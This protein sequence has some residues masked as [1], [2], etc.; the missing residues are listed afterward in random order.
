MKA[1]GIVYKVIP[2]KETSS[3]VYLY[4]KFGHISVKSIGSKNKKNQSFLFDN[5]GNIVSFLITDNEFPTLIEYNLIKDQYDLTKDISMLKAFGIIIKIISYISNDLSH[6]RIYS[7]ILKTL[8][9]IRINPKKALSIF[10]IKMLYNFGVNPNL[11]T[12]VLCNNNLITSFSIPL[13]GAL[14]DIHKNE[15]NNDLLKIWQEYYYEKKDI[16]LYSDYDFDLLLNN[17]I[18]Y[19]NIHTN[20]K[21]K[22]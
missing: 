9:D 11:K 16:N 19:Y 7:F 17:I 21:L 2:Y 15:E 1:E 3:I 6:N 20:I 13:G 12:C 18:E 8:D 5:V 22:V 10:L 4:T 14:C